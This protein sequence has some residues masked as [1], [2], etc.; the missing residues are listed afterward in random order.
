MKSETNAQLLSV[1][2]NDDPFVSHPI[3]ESDREYMQAG[4]RLYYYGLRWGTAGGG[5]AAVKVGPFKDEEEGEDYF[6][7]TLIDMDYSE[8]KWWEVMRWGESKPSKSVI[9]KIKQLRS[10]GVK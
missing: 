1:C 5:S 10:G 8:P 7:K 9:A 4:G 2:L 6:V 3:S